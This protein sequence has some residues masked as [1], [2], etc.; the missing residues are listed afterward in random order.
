MLVHFCS[1][2]KA[3][4]GYAGKKRWLKDFEDI[5]WTGL[6]QYWNSE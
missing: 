5:D 2:N 1:K 3:T 4:N 6:I